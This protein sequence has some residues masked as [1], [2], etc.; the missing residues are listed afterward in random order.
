[1]TGYWF[2]DRPQGWQPPAALVD[3]LQAGPPPVVVGFGSITV[4]DPEETTVLV[5]SALRAARQ[6][7]LLL[8]GWGGLSQADLPDD[9]FKLEAVPHDWLFPR[10]A[11]VVH[12]GGA[13]TTAAALRAGVPSIVVPN[14]MDQPFWAQRVVALGA[15]PRP[16]P[17]NRLN[18]ARLSAALRAAVEDESFR[19]RAAAVGRRL[20]AED[21]V[22]RAVEAFERHPAR[23][24]ALR[25]RRQ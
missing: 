6:R 3:F 23:V 17:R 15:G 2:L 10:A 24:L 16:I 1:M 8:T 14:F 19:A 11:A 20:R 25:A 13:G 9:V 5:L 21:G 4:R 18:A 22:G 12:H 7:G